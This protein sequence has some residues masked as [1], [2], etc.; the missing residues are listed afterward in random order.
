MM[1]S[2]LKNRSNKI[3]A[4]KNIAAFVVLSSFL[5]SSALFAQTPAESL[6]NEKYHAQNWGLFKGMSRERVKTLEKAPK[7]AEY[8][9]YLPEVD[10]SAAFWIW[11]YDFKSENFAH[12]KKLYFDNDKLIKE[13]N[14]SNPK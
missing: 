5:L 11:E 9:G 12:K 6:R 8:S 3:V 13:E 2:M 7:I 1:S 4:M 14:W 10:P